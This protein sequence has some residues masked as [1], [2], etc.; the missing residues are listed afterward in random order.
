MAVASTP[1]CSPACSGTC[2]ICRW[3]TSTASKSF[4]GRARHYGVPMRSTG[5]S[6]LSPGAHSKPW[7]P[8]CRPSPAPSAMRPRCE[9]APTNCSMAAPLPA[10]MPAPWSVTA[11]AGPMVAAHP[12]DRHSL[13]LAVALTPSSH[14]SKPC[15]VR[16]NSMRRVPTTRPSPARPPS[17]T[18]PAAPHSTCSGSGISPRIEPQKYALPIPVIAA[19]TPRC[20]ARAATRSTCRASTRH[21]WAAGIN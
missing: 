18:T 14:S 6:T 8:Q 17:R 20:T 9:P 21:S 7:A 5:S 15:S 2:S 4:V 12:T 16:Q 10:S 1:R 19:T 3:T 11:A 13:P